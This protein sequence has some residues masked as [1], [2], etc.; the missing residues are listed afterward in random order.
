MATRHLFVVF[1][2]AVAVAAQSQGTKPPAV[3]MPGDNGK[4][5]VPYSMGAKGEELVFTLEKA[6][7]A[8][9]AFTHDDV[10]MAEEN[11]R[12][13][14]VS[15]AVQNP[16]AV[17]RVF[18]GSSFKFTVVSPDDQ[19]YVA[20]AYSYH[21][22]R[23]NWMELSLKPAQKVRAFFV[24]PIHPKGVVNKLIVQRGQKTSVLRYDLRDKVKP[25]MGPFAAENQID[26]LEIG[27]AKVGVPFGLGPYD[28]SIEKVEELQESAGFKAG[29]G[30]KLIVTTVTITNKSKYKP[31]FGPGMA[32][33]KMFDENGEEMNFLM[34]AKMSSADAPSQSLMEPEQ[35]IRF[36]FVF[37]A[38]SSVKPVYMRLR[39][40]VSAR[41]VDVSLQ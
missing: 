12:L 8:V 32:V 5:G 2:A 20:P 11:Q 10:I 17:D 6:E 16:A 7:F 3:Q 13:L 26:V 19:N 41:S 1:A 27:K 4:V 28:Y 34:H 9:R 38:P 15:F 23:L 22:E 39:D 31:S 36:R 14:I 37:E 18:N 33:P 21:P 30:N 35:M 29:E 40:L 25:F 24:V